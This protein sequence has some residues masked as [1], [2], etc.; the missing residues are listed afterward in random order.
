[1]TKKIGLSKGAIIFIVIIIIYF[2]ASFFNFAIFDSQC[3]ISNDLFEICST[4]PFKYMSENNFI[5]K[6]PLLTVLSAF[7]MNLNGCFKDCKV[8]NYR[9]SF[10]PELEDK[11]LSCVSECTITN[12]S[13]LKQDFSNE[14]INKCPTKYTKK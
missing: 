5:A 1:M 10:D 2:I 13:K 6:Y 8:R 4:S 11:C 3:H 14:C 9:C 7:G 12:D